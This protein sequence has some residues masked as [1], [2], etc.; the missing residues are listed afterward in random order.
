MKVVSD[1]AQKGVLQLTEIEALEFFG[2]G[3]CGKS[4]WNSSLS[5]RDGYGAVNQFQCSTRCL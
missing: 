4:S 3:S 1:D 5:L 2:F